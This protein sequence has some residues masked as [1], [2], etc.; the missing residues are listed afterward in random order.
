MKEYVL[1]IDMGT[2]S[3]KVGLFDLKGEPIAFA[4]ETYP[5]YTPRSGWAEQKAEDWWNAICAATRALMEKSGANPAS[6]IGMSVDTTCCTVLMADEHM[7]ILRPAIM[8]MDVRASR[9]AKAITR[10]G[11]SGAQIQRLWQC[12]GGIHA[13]KNRRSWLKENERELYEQGGAR[14]RMR[15]L[16]DA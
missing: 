14:I 2:S 10:T 15:G 4:D 11:R 16:A 6:I 8:W 13:G 7:N 5:L 12:I 9:Q 3:V 1:G